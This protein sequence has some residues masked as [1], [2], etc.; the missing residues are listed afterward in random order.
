MV[1]SLLLVRSRS[2]HLTTDSIEA[3]MFS[4]FGWTPSLRRMLR[5]RVLPCGCTVG[6]YETRSGGVVQI[7]DA[8]SAHCAY[9]THVVDAV[10]AADVGG[11]ADADVGRAHPRNANP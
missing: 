3:R 7:I 10:V 9:V 11:H 6:V 5:G 4:L 1:Q 2:C 8:R